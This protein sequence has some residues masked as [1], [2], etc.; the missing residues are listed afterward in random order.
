MTVSEIVKDIRDYIRDNGIGI[1]GWYVGIT[2][3]PN[4]RLFDEHK[5]DKDN[6]RWIHCP[7]SSH[8]NARKAEK[9]LLEDGHKG[10]GGGGDEDTKYVYAYKITITTK[11][12]A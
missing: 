1:H 11:E 10:G 2:A 6:G 9:T 4:V 7:A 12:S 3:Y 8:T 5:V